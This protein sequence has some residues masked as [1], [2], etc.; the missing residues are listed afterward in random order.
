MAAHEI[1]E[2]GLYRLWIASN[3][4]GYVLNTEQNPATGVA[5]LH[6]AHCPHI[7]DHK[8][9]VLAGG[10]SRKFVAQTKK[11]IREEATRLGRIGI[12]KWTT[13]GTCGA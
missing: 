1:L 13:C 7:A 9:G 5:T 8:S 6:Y 4:H 12:I 10:V 2:D 11:E 3:P